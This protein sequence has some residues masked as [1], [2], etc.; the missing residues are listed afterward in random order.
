MVNPWSAETF[1][2]GHV[3]SDL[4]TYRQKMDAF[5]NARRAGEKATE[6]RMKVKSIRAEL[7]KVV[8]K[9]L[10]RPFFK[11]E[12]LDIVVPPIERL[13]LAE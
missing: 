9:D 1:Q 6:L 12:D 11:N 5:L 10:L 7:L 2:F 13:I 4:L 3:L 8:P